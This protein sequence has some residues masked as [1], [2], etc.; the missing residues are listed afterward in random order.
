[1]N[2]GTGTEENPL[3]NRRYGAFIAAWA[4][5]DSHGTFTAAWAVE[6]CNDA[7]CRTLG[8]ARRELIGKS[9]VDLSPPV[10]ADGALSPERW[11]RRE[12][13]ARAGMQQWFQWQ[14]LKHDGNPAHTLVH[15]STIDSERGPR[16]LAQVHDLSRLRGAGWALEESERR[17]QHVLDNTKAVI[18]AKDREGRYI[19]VN[20]ELERSVRRP[21]SEI[22]G[23]TDH[24]LWPQELAEQFRSNDLKV[25]EQGQAIEFE[26]ADTADDRARVLHSFKF[27]LFDADGVP[28][29]VCGIAT[30]ITERKRI[31]DALRSA[32]LAVSSAQGPTVFQEL[33]RFLATTLEVDGA[34]IAAPAGA[35]RRT[36]RIHAFYLDGEVRENFDYGIAGTACEAVMGQSFRI[37]PSR[38]QES[39]PA[40]VDFARMAF[41]SYA[42]FPLT[43]SAGAPLGLI[44]AV[45]RKAM[46]DSG[47]VESMLK[48]FAARAA[49]ELERMRNEEALRISESSY[50]AIFE[51]SEDAIVIHDWDTGAIVDVNP[52]ACATY[53]Y[54]PEEMKRLTAGDLS[55]NMSPF[56]PEEVASQIEQA[57][58]GEPVHFEWHRRNRDGSLHWDD[59]VLKQAVIAGK[60]RIVA[61]TREITARKRAEQALRASEEQYRQIFNASM[62]GM[63]LRDADYRVVDANPAALAMSG[64]T[65]EEVVGTDRALLQAADLTLSIRSRLH[66]VL[67]GERLRF[68]GEAIGKDGRR[69][70]IEFRGMPVQYRGR[71]HL[72]TISHDLT[73][74]RR[75]EAERVQLEAQ[76]RQAQKMEAIGHLTGGI[77]H[78]FNNL[79]TTILGYVVLAD[80]RVSDGGD[81]RLGRYLEQARLSC[82]RAR[83]LIQQ[84]LTFSRGQRGEP[85][86][87]ALPPLVKESI[88][89]FGSSLPSTI[90]IE[91]D[92]AREVPAVML[93]PVHV[94]Q[95]L[96]NLCLNARDAMNSVGTIRV[97][98]RAATGNHGVCTACRNAVEGDRVELSI[99]DDGPGIAEGIL[100]RMFEPFFTTKEAGKGSGMG[101]AM[102]HGIV[103]EHGGH[104]VVETAPGKGAR[105]RVLFEAL[106]QAASP[107]EVA[108]LDT[109]SGVKSSRAALSG[110]VLV[111]DDEV[112]VAGFMRDLLETWGLEVTLAHDGSQARELIGRAPDRY[113]LVVTDQ[114]MPR[115][116]GLEL[117]RELLSVNPRLPVLLY[118][119]FSDDMTDV[120]VKR[121]GIRALLRKPVDPGE[122]YRVLGAHLPRMEPVR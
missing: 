78:D 43:G 66:N 56:T 122:L 113:D 83:D 47:F 20:H 24:E 93:D 9:A 76:L 68:E 84:M 102:V 44:A 94:D 103:H 18:F 13:A 32:A 106:P 62:D 97:G 101:L 120:E 16:L 81:A 63:V 59:V 39:F 34:F 98:V 99:E 49:A 72:L 15:L 88:K 75:A 53:G 31:E 19:F 35:D 45:S 11:Q 10:Q 104:V 95:V 14:F 58:S 36:M 92:L 2:A 33:V 5:E 107:R 117:A 3:A 91:T 115:M 65:R 116:T 100:D 108:A 29:A 96:L 105:F 6:D 17:L 77:A 71:P 73:E 85:R 12:H 110:H 121:A 40:D 25:L 7:L 54:T 67:A 26:V 61:F 23:R 42:G 50:R 79:L 38:L 37:F 74:R 1:M 118:T 64:Y 89:L 57:K 55:S 114:L 119:G 51:A 48:I 90:E 22:V 82:E 28:Y 27:P 41:E 70:D 46:Q 30:D 80:E 109:S 52:K 69:I 86:P 87:L 112:A 60:R 4:V 21:A 8:R 111:V